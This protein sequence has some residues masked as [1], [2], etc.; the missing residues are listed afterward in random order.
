MGCCNIKFLPAIIHRNRSRRNDCQ[1]KQSFCNGR[2]D[3]GCE[4]RAWIGCSVWGT[5][6]RVHKGCSVWRFRHRNH[7]QEAGNT[8]HHGCASDYLHDDYYGDGLDYPIDNSCC[9]GFCHK[10]EWRF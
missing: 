3:T 5:V 10:E 6:F 7:K 4:G 9:G 8:E 2:T 1:E